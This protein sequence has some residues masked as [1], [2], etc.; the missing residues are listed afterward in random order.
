MHPT[1]QLLHLPHF[2]HKVPMIPHETIAPQVHLKA[3]LGFRHQRNKLGIIVG[4]V[5]ERLA[6]ITPI[7]HM[8]APL[9]KMIPG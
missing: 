9:L 3:A 8:K 7:E 4:T 5:K 2:R 6:V 1:A